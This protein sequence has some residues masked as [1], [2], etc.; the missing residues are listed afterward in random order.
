MIRN[1]FFMWQP[2]NHAAPPVG[3]KPAIQV[4]ATIASRRCAD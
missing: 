3:D 4:N 1:A 2:A